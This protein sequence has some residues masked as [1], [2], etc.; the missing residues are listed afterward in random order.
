MRS[1]R[2]RPFAVNKVNENTIHTGEIC[3]DGLDCD[4]STLQGEPRDRSFAEFPSID[5]D[6]RGAAYITYNDS[7]NQSSRRLMSWWPG[8][9]AARACS[10]PLVRSM[11]RPARSRCRKPAANAT[12][13]TDSLTL[14]ARRR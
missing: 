7:L 6:S 10:H 9:S 2:I 3:L 11:N 5:I 12:I 1:A 8:K 4:I 14:A 13:R